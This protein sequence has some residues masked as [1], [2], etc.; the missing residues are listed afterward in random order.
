MNNNIN[1]VNIR[2]INNNA[3]A[4]NLNRNGLNSSGFEVMIS[5]V[6]HTA[7]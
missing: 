1:K 7:A 6:Y 3:G 2:G 5:I 4:T